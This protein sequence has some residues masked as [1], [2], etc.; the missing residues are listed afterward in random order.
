MRNIKAFSCGRPHHGQYRNVVFLSPALGRLGDCGC[1][2]AGER[3][4]A[5]KAEQ[6]AARVARLHH[7][8]RQ[9]CQLISGAQCQVH[10]F[11]IGLRIQTERQRPPAIGA[12]LPLR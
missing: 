2:L 9:Q 6:F 5:I 7:A 3:G 10:R 11:V 1:G 12:S 4:H 8:V